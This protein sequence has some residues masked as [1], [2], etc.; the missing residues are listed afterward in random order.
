[1]L[2]ISHMQNAIACSKSVL[3]ARKTKSPLGKSSAAPHTRRR[4]AVNADQNHIALVF[5]AKSSLGVIGPAVLELCNGVVGQ[6]RPHNA[7]RLVRLH[8][9]E[10][11]P[12]TAVGR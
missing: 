12:K 6:Q 10:R 1:M 11:C 9:L 7:A 4:Y 2:A 3:F 8:V 5:T